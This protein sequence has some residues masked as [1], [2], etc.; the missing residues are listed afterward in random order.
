M[1]KIKKDRP[2]DSLTEKYS[3]YQKLMS[4]FA[5]VLR[6]KKIATKLSSIRDL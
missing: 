6:F 4:V 2:L 3:S 5:Y 1:S